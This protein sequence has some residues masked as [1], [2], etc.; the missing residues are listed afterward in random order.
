MSSA[1]SPWRLRSSPQPRHSS[2]TPSSSARS[3]PEYQPPASPDAK[4]RGSREPHGAPWSR[5]ALP[6]NRTESDLILALVGAQLIHADVVEE[7][8]KPGAAHGDQADP[9]SLVELVCP[10]PATYPALAVLTGIR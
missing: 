3:S 8:G 7:R 10:G 5:A 2:C 6:L 1:G 4:L 9:R